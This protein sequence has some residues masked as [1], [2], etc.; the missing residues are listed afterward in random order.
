MKNNYCLALAFLSMCLTF[1]IQC[2]ES[3]LFKVE[4]ASSAIDL[5]ANWRNADI[6]KEIEKIEQDIIVIENQYNQLQ[7]E[8]IE[9]EAKLS[10]AY[11]HA[12]NLALNGTY[13]QIT[14][15]RE[16]CRALEQA[17]AEKKQHYKRLNK[18]LPRYKQ[19]IP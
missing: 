3:L 1:F 7:K 12:M 17:I 14:S 11:A 13:Q 19:N 10:R 5:D 16:N 8:V 9:L 6:E 4:K 18:I 15:A 2:D